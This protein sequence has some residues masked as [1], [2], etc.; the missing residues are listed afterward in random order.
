MAKIMKSR[1][2][3]RE[4]GKA[5][6]KNRGKTT[7][8]EQ[9]GLGNRTDIV[10][11]EGEK[12]HLT[13]K[14]SVWGFIIPMFVLFIYIACVLTLNYIYLFVP[15]D[16]FSEGFTTTSQKV[17]AIMFAIGLAL[18]IAYI[19]HKLLRYRKFKLLITNKRIIIK[20]DFITNI[21]I[22]RVSAAM[23]NQN[24]LSTLFNYG[25]L[26]ISSINGSVQTFY[27]IPS[28]LRAQRAINRVIDMNNSE[29]EEE[30][31]KRLTLNDL[32]E[33]IAGVRGRLRDLR[34]TNDD[35]RRTEDPRRNRRRPTR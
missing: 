1:K 16:V 25:D 34:R 20:D 19:V 15:M 33:D 31:P 2:R 26:V 35:D 4:S 29:G 11:G 5:K 17:Y 3:E 12:V 10:L 9:F 27:S 6:G 13:T 22:K 18:I 30:K 14:L 23:V 28:P 7:R 24:P 8:E 21:D 32:D